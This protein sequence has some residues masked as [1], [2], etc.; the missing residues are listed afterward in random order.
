MFIARINYYIIFE[1]FLCVMVLLFGLLT[2]MRY[3]VMLNLHDERD[4]SRLKNEFIFMMMFC[5]L[6]LVLNLLFLILQEKL[7]EEPGK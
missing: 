1:A 5:G 7:L 2:L 4:K 3:F 6:R